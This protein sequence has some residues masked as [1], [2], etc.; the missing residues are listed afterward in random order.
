MEIGYDPGKNAR[1]IQERGL[2]FD[3]VALLDWDMAMVRQDTRRDYGEARFQAFV[4]GPDGKPYVVVYT[5]RGTT[6]WVISFRRANSKE[7]RRHARK[8][9]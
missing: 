2:S 5:P 9:A 3:D 4:M 6:M 7:R 1:N 8:E